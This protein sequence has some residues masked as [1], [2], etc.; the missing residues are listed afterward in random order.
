V[1]VVVAVAAGGVV[2]VVVVAASVVVVVSAAAALLGPPPD[3]FKY[4]L[5]A[6]WPDSFFRFGAIT[7][8]AEF[9]FLIAASLSD[10]AVFESQD[11]TA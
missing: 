2:A 10:R 8:S 9:F 5:M 4:L 11:F 1:V 3:N 7:A 6:P